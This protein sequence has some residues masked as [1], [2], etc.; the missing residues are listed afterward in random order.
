MSKYK[1]L[2]K[3]TI[4][5][6]WGNAGSKIIG[7]ILLPFYTK[8]LSVDDYGT[9]DVIRVYVAFLMSFVALSVQE[10]IFIFPSG[11]TKNRQC[12]YFSSG[13]VFSFICI[14]VFAVIFV[15]IDRFFIFYNIENSFSRNIS[16]IF[17]LLVF[18]F[19]Q[20]FIQNFIRSINKMAVY[21]LTGIVLTISTA[22]FSFIF[23]PNQ[24]VKGFIFSLIIANFIATLFSFVVSGSYQYFNLFKA[25]IKDCKQM[26]KYS[27]PIIP[28]GIMWWLVSS[29]NRPFLESTVGMAGIGLYAVANKLPGLI[30]MVFGIFNKAWTVSVLE[31]FNKK[32]YNYY[33]NQILKIVFSMQIIL[34]IIIALFAKY[35]IYVFT[36]SDYYESWKYIPLLTLGVLFSNMSAFIGSNFLA[37]KKSKY[38]FYSSIWAGVSS[39]I[40]NVLLV[41]YFKIWGACIAVVGSHLVAMLARIFFSWKYNKINNLHYFILSFSINLV[42]ILVVMIPLNLLFKWLCI[43]LCIFLLLYINRDLAKEYVSKIILKINRK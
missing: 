32:N 41:R 6:F 22:F 2:G 5:V 14:A 11:Q 9:T 13:L 28:N 10:A 42:V 26:M 43:I 18:T 16:S 15:I 30:N 4:L 25:N 36:E 35:F 1:R 40:L 38:F 33:Y 21:S 27:V 34:S 29:V 19:L 3:N 20:A 31:E 24:G 17:F 8:W 7:L 37:T 23:I 12:S 39:I